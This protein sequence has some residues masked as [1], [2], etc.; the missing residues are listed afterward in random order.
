VRHEAS[1]HLYRPKWFCA[2]FE[3]PEDAI[4]NGPDGTAFC[5]YCGTTFPDSCEE[6]GF[7]SHL[8][9]DHNFGG[10]YK[11]FERIDDFFEHLEHWHKVVP[12]TRTDEPENACSKGKATPSN[13]AGATSVD[14]AQAP[15]ALRS[16]D[17]STMGLSVPQAQDDVPPPL[18][19]PIYFPHTSTTSESDA[20]SVNHFDIAGRGDFAAMSPG[21][22]IPDEE[23]NSLNLMDVT[24]EKCVT[25]KRR[26]S[27]PVSES[28]KNS[29]R[30]FPA[31]S[32]C[33]PAAAVR[34]S[35]TEDRTMSPAPPQRSTAS[36]KKK[37]E[38]KH[39]CSICQRSYTRHATL[40][41]HERT[42]TGEK[43]FS[44]NFEGCNQTF[45]QQGDKTRHE[46]AQH[47]ENTFICGSSNSEGPSWGCGKAF[48]RRDGL[49][50]H[51]RKTKKG[52][53]CLADRDKLMELGRIGDQD[54][55]A[56]A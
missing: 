15:Y 39:V 44:C 45:A 6:E 25:R 31:T 33:I 10:C 5:E 11:G 30:A 7:L 21:S 51:H 20:H 49:L 16:A 40:V 28:A 55:P 52:K 9:D 46:K 43:P 13:G 12:G 27:S 32:A 3:N 42:H 48:P 50:E 17:A 1:H 24:S 53:Q 35:A 14:A 36:R 2:T 29:P 54:N 47:T 23:L 22:R 34:S 18:R 26:M 4:S 56:F 19:P 38:H 37:S 8:L 41:N